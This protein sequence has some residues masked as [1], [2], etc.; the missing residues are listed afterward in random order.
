MSVRFKRSPAADPNFLFAFLSYSFLL[1]LPGL[2]GHWPSGGTFLVLIQ[3]PLL[4]QVSEMIRRIPAV[5]DLAG[6]SENSPCGVSAKH[7]A[8]G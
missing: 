3:L 6:K 7:L 1:P 8:P 2:V 5:D 4:P